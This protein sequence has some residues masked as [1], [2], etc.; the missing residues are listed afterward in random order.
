MMAL[1]GVDNTSDTAEST[2]TFR[3]FHM[4]ELSYDGLLGLSHNECDNLSSLFFSNSSSCS[5]SDNLNE[6]LAPLLSSLHMFTSFMLMNIFIAKYFSELF[7]I[8]V[9]RCLLE[10]ALCCL[11]ENF[12]LDTLSF[13][14]VLLFCPSDLFPTLSLGIFTALVTPLLHLFGLK[15]CS[16]LVTLCA[17]DIEEWNIL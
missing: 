2:C 3:C 15:F 4:M 16:P 13:P 17:S 1:I 10:L 14:Y 12:F 9:S 6:Y 5:S 11:H 8:I 7:I